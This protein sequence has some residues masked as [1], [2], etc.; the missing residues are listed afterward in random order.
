MILEALERLCA[1][2]REPRSPLTTTGLN[3]KGTDPP[4]R[5]EIEYPFR[6]VEERVSTCP[7]ER[8]ARSRTAKFHREER[9]AIANKSEGTEERSEAPAPRER[10]LSLQSK[11]RR[12]RSRGLNTLYRGQR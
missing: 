1:P 4:I 9:G 2:P 6:G 10:M 11:R 7:S 8:I 12:G 3:F 5:A